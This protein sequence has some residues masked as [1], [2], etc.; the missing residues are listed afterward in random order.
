MLLA[1]VGPIAAPVFRGIAYF[2]G[3]HTH[4]GHQMNSIGTVFEVQALRG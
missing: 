3:T 1:T 2:R 4:T